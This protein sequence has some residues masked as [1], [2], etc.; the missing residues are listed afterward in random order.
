MCLRD[1]DIAPVVDNWVNHSRLLPVTWII[2]PEL[3]TETSKH[4]K[5]L[6]E[7]DFFATVDDCNDWQAVKFTCVA[8]S[9]HLHP[10]LH[11]YVDFF[12]RLAMVFEHFNDWVN[13]AHHWEVH[14]ADETNQV[15]SPSLKEIA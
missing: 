9:T 4:C 13:L 10:V 2:V 14:D 8:T 15:L 12:V 7:I 11:V 6:A 5:W 3:D 1:E